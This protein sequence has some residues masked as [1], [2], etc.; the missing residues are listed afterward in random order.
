METK[1][2]ADLL[3]LTLDRSVFTDSETK[4]LIEISMLESSCQEELME[5]KIKQFKSRFVL[6]K[7]DWLDYVPQTS[8]VSIDFYDMENLTIS[9]ENSKS[10][11]LTIKGLGTFS[12]PKYN[13]F[14]GV[15]KFKEQMKFNK[16]EG[17]VIDTIED[18]VNSF[19]A[20]IDNVARRNRLDLNAPAEKAIYDAM[21]EVEKLPADEKLTEAVILLSKAKDLVSDFIDLDLT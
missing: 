9:E 13:F 19:T 1:T 7:E 10:L 5:E 2:R 16:E 4:A 12:I 8:S 18:D 6:K 17:I 15:D 20:H 14:M 21:Q 11:R 3:R